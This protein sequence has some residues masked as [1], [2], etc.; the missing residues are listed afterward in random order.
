MIWSRYIF[1][2]ERKKMKKPLVLSAA[3]VCSFITSN[4]RGADLIFKVP[5][6]LLTEEFFKNFH[7]ITVMEHSAELLKK[8]SDAAALY[9]KI[10]ITVSAIGGASV[11]LNFW[12]SSKISDLNKEKETLVD[13]NALLRSSIEDL[14]A[15][16]KNDYQQIQQKEEFIS[17]LEI[18]KEEKESFFG[19][20]T[21]TLLPKLKDGFEKETRKR[22]QLDFRVRELDQERTLLDSRLSASRNTLTEA[23]KKTEHLSAER[24]TTSIQKD[25][26]ESQL[27]ALK[28]VSKQQL[29]ELSLLQA[30]ELTLRSQMESL[31]EYYKIGESE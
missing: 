17:R 7:P 10:G 23:L 21:E 19:I 25:A 24:L 22:Q 4:V 9:K 18:E 13:K 30:K 28:S 3:L 20:M 11:V 27:S 16:I 14:T 15:N 2:L 8:A 1:Y 29:E 6:P 12:K 26:L 5:T 31:Q